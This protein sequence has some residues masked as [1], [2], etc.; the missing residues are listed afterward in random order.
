MT[1]DERALLEHRWAVRVNL[2]TDARHAA[3]IALRL[4][5]VVRYAGLAVPA[6]VKRA[7]VKLEEFAA[8]VSRQ[9]EQERAQRVLSGMDDARFQRELERGPQQ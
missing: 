1:D 4:L 5:D 8:A 9:V 6:E 3:T 7:A 2:P